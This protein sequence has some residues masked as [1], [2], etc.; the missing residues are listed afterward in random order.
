[1]NGR[2]I[3]DTGNDKVERRVDYAQQLAEQE[4]ADKKG[5]TSQVNPQLDKRISPV[6]SSD[7]DQNFQPI[8]DSFPARTATVHIVQAN[9]TLQSIALSMYGDSQYWYVI[10]DAN[11]L[12]GNDQLVFGFRLTVPNIVANTR[13]NADTFRP[14]DVEAALGKTDPTLPPPPPPPKG[15]GCGA[16]ATILVVAVAIV[17]TVFTAGAA[18]S[19]LATAAGGGVTGG[20]FAAGTAALTGSLA[21]TGVSAAA[22][23]A[24]GI[25]A[26]VIGGALGS[27]ISQGVAI[28]AGLQKGF[29]FKGVALAAIGAGVTA[30]IGAALGGSSKVVEAISKFAKGNP[31]TFAA[32]NGAA[33]RALTQG[34]AVATNLQ[35]SFSWKQVAVSAIAAPVARYVGGRAA[36]LANNVGLPS[37][38]AFADRF[39]SNV[40]GALVRK[41]SG[42]R[43]K[44]DTLVAEAIGTA[45]GEAIV[46]GLQGIGQRAIQEVAKAS[47]SQ[48]AIPEAKIVATRLD[49]SSDTETALQTSRP[50]IGGDKRLLFASN[51]PASILDALGGT[52]TSSTTPGLAETKPAPAAGT[53]S[54][55]L[56]EVVTTA[57]RELALGDLIDTLAQV[58][59]GP[60]TRV[61]AGVRLFDADAIKSALGSYSGRI[62]RGSAFAASELL[63]SSLQ[64]TEAFN[65][66]DAQLIALFPEGTSSRAKLYNSIVAAG[67]Y[68][69]EEVG[70]NLLEQIN[71]GASGIDLTF[72][73]GQSE[74]Y[75][76]G[77][78]S[79]LGIYSQTVASLTRSAREIG[80]E[81]I[82]RAVE[83]QVNAL[84]SDDR[85]LPPRLTI[86]EAG[87]QR[88]VDKAVRLAAL[89]GLVGD[90][91]GL[92]VAA[93]GLLIPQGFSRTQFR[94]FSS[95]VKTLVSQEQ[96]PQGRILVQGSRVRRTAVPGKDIDV[97]YVMSAK[98]FEAFVAKRVSEVSAGTAKKI[99]EQVRKN[100]KVNARGISRTFESRTYDIVQPVLPKDVSKLQFSIAR[101]G[102]S[103]YIPPFI[104]IK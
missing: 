16:V 21:V 40:G 91:P 80:A 23:T 77:L 82:E 13:N 57:P 84:R 32:L 76:D 46:E 20:V 61:S 66:G 31:Y 68:F 14:Y 12:T 87:V 98:D 63:K 59:N 15:K 28:A 29:D 79:S 6:T 72:V 101:E 86:T 4:K 53:I 73:R 90:L 17:A 69:T 43:V 5:R 71:S 42:S 44:T 52:T 78:V 22:A 36:S 49:G 9:E 37:A 27:A 75:L 88:S 18:A 74:L 45:A 93:R 100:G 10:A 2:G 60:R 97:L 26:A 39:A 85:L 89:A 25:G 56:E 33:S 55:V 34:I 102:S 99:L 65:T 30:G 70:L 1:L 54:G 104:P 67:G 64:A 95:A 62:R 8:N 81:S 58:A 19:A 47:S 7:F 96:L 11:G 50:L 103:F 48:D 51:D 41:V 83:F 24:I 94:E 35:K 92:I 3:G 38:G